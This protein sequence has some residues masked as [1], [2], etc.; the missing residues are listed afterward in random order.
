MRLTPLEVQIEV[1]IEAQIE[2]QTEGVH[3]WRADL[4]EPPVERETLARTLSEDERA[5]AGHFHRPRDRDRFVTGRGLL[6]VLLGD[7]LGCPP[8]SL[9]FRYNACGKPALAA[10]DTHLGF[11]LSHS[12]GTALF[13]LAWGREVG[14]DIERVR[15]E[16]PAASLVERF[17]PADAA[18]LRALPPARR[19]EAFTQAWVRR[20]AYLKALGTGFSSATMP[21]EQDQWTHKDIGVGPEC[22]AALVVGKMKENGEQASNRPTSHLFRSGEPDRDPARRLQETTWRPILGCFPG[23]R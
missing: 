20:E 17:L 16:I 13:A 12:D 21:P 3:V 2:V 8:S 5:R 11:N 4:D 1:Q 19:A 7:A 10:G 15:P 6:R 14:V 22:R 9:R 23:W 18:A